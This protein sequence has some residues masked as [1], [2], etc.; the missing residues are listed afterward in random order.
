MRFR[1][2]SIS[3]RWK[4]TIASAIA[5]FSEQ[6]II[7]GLALQITAFIKICSISTYHFSLTTCLA[8]VATTTHIITVVITNHYFEP[9]TLAQRTRNVLI[10]I[11]ALAVGITIN[12]AVLGA[13]WPYTGCL[14]QGS[15][16][17]DV[18]K[19]I[20]GPII[21]CF[22]FFVM[23]VGIVKN[24]DRS[25]EVLYFITLCLIAGVMA[26]LFLRLGYGD[27]VKSI[28]GNENEWSFG[29]IVVLLLLL[30]PFI[31]IATAFGGL[32]TLITYIRQLLSNVTQR[33]RPSH[34]V[35]T[36]LYTV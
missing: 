21:L 11:N 18:G 10:T 35:K 26:T 2:Q 30:I 9:S 28:E 6:Q 22:V 12:I 15:Y 31:G 23:V 25:L 27:W 1:H 19:A 17:V 33:R 29:Q 8:C 34:D 36:S 14:F 24:N 4:A 20:G 5:G 13:S 7:T 16:H 32:S 3:E